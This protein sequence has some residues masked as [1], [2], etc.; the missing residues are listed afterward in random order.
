[1][2]QFDR[3]HISLSLVSLNRWLSAKD[4]LPRVMANI[5]LLDM[6][7][8]LLR[9][10]N[11]GNKPTLKGYASDSEYVTL[12]LCVPHLK[13]ALS[14]EGDIFAP[15]V[16]ANIPFL[17]MRQVVR[18]ISETTNRRGCGIWMNGEDILVRLPVEH[19]SL[20][21]KHYNKDIKR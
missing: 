12:S 15:S 11:G 4:K 14:D 6:L 2:R 18:D 5:Q 9:K 21:K 16:V 20:K 8:D 10:Q 7:F 17:L 13:Y 1:M 19:K 3:L